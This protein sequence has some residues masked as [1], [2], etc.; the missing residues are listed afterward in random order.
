VHDRQTGTT[1]R[2]SLGSDGVQGNEESYDPAISADGRFVAFWSYASN[3]V[4]GDSNRWAD[5]F[6]HD[7]KT[8][9]TR[10]VSI[11]SGGAQGDGGSRFASISADGS[12]VAFQSDA[13]NLAPRDSNN[14]SD[15]FVHD[16]KRGTT[17]RVSRG[18]GGVQ[19]NGR[20]DS[21]AISADGRFVAFRSDASN[22]VPGDTN[23]ESDVFVRTL[24]P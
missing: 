8:G 24:A 21:G 9:T 12:L 22:L 6:V 14:E 18:P 1:Q 10:R 5:V 16:R 17:R 7:R 4:P 15:V 3:L 20:S 19:G 13:T 2:V 11:G 23:N